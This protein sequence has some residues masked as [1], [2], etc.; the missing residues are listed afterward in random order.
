LELPVFVMFQANGWLILLLK[1]NQHF[2]TCL[3]DHLSS[4]VQSKRRFF[5]VDS[6]VCLYCDRNYCYMISRNDWLIGRNQITC[7]CTSGLEQW[8]H[9]CVVH[10]ICIVCI[11]FWPILSPWIFKMSSCGSNVGIEMSALLII[12]IVNN[13]LFHSNSHINQIPP[14]IIHILGFFW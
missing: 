5:V 14:Q 4:A 7:H 8:S 3:Y 10:W 9:M 11:S 13:A 6:T 2:L 1:A 12:A